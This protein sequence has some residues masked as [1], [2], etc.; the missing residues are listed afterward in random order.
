ML[1]AR[2]LGERSAYDR[3]RGFEPIQQEQMVLQFVETHGRITPAEAAELCRADAIGPTAF[4]NVLC[5]RDFSRAKGHVAGA[6]T[7]PGGELNGRSHGG[8]P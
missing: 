2:R 3:Q 4:S 1:L 8:T 7:T 5:R 6:S